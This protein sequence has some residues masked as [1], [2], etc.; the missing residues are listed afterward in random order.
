MLPS[1]RRRINKELQ[2]DDPLTLGDIE[3]Y[4]KKKIDTR[5]VRDVR[6]TRENGKMV[7]ESLKRKIKYDLEE[8]DD[9]LYEIVPG[10]IESNISDNL[11]SYTEK[12]YEDDDKEY[13]NG[14]SIKKHKMTNIKYPFAE[15]SSKHL[16]RDLDNIRSIASEN[17]DD[18]EILVELCIYYINK[19]AY[20]PFLEFMLYKSSETDMFYFPNFT[21]NT[22][23]YN[24]LENASLLLNNLFDANLYS[25]KGRLIETSSMNNIKSAH[26][27]DR[28]ILVFELKERSE[29]VIH[30]KDEDKFWWTT[31]SEIFNYRK[32]LFYDISDTVIDVFLA[33]TQII[34]LYYNDLLIETP[35]VV[36]NGSSS[37]NAKYNAVFSISKS[38]NESRYGPFYYFTDLYNS[39]RYACYDHEK[40]EKYEKGGLVKF[41]IYT[42]KLKMFLKNSKPD[43]SE[44]AKYI[45]NRHPIELNTA[46]F[47]D[48]DCKWTEHYNCAYNGLYNIKINNNHESANG[49]NE[50]KVDDE[51]GHNNG[52][53]DDEEEDN[54]FIHNYDIDTEDVHKYNQEHKPRKSNSSEYEDTLLQRGGKNKDT[55]HLAMRIC[56][57]E[58]I[59]QTPLLYCYINTNDIPNKYENDFKKYKII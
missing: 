48:N 45:F 46:Q 52:E 41:I 13:D 23:K 6:D 18:D 44:M 24:V 20:K 36:Y 3:R 50:N 59:F 10:Y 4:Y 34:K 51:Y 28:V 49:N 56:L 53:D 27:N 58:Y 9:H 17:D 5:D 21:H 35:M 38:N 57:N 31:V 22:S 25:F 26:I 40:H 55:Y 29:D 32:I 47:R 1:S 30:M 11:S 16:T 2:K 54:D 42:G 19:S 14:L 39:M 43:S 33:Y 7:K 15:K 8:S 37:N 12:E